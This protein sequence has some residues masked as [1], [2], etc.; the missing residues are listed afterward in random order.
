MH[1]VHI[2]MEPGPG[3]PEAGPWIERDL[4]AWL[5]GALTPRGDAGPLLV[6]IDG[7]GGSG[8]TTL[9]AAIG[10]VLASVATVATVATDDLAWHHSVLS[11]QP[12]LVE[13]VL[14]PIRRGEEVDYRP[15]AW[16]ERGRAGAIR[17]GRDARVVLIE[18]TGALDASIRPLLDL[19]IWVQ[20]DYELARQRALA[21]D[22]ATGAN[23]DAAA[24][25]TFW[26][27]W[28]REEVPY[29]IDQAPWEAADAIVCGT[30]PVTIAAGRV[31]VARERG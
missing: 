15:D 19:G 10:W 16:V 4:R 14:E 18:G 25:E 31:L 9:A 17:V 28:Q 30:S 2:E 11:W 6:G 8:K 27:A 22:I 3:E 24:A 13:H 12:V 7:R 1:I 29:L 23:G 5:S 26:V 21:R 20:C